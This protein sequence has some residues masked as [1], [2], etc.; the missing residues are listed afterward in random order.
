MSINLDSAARGAAQAAPTALTSG[1]VGLGQVLHAT[2]ASVWR[3]KAL[4]GAIVATTLALGTITVFA[5]PASYTSKAYISGGFVASSA[6]AQ[7]ENSGNAPFISLDLTRVI[8]T[9]RSRLQSHDLARR[10]VQQLGLEK[11][12][13]EV[14]ERHLL[15]DKFFG[16]AA[17]TQ[18]DQIDRAALRLL[19]RLSVESDLLHSYLITVSYTGTDP[20]LAVTIT[21][22]FVV[23]F[24]RSCNLQ[25]LYRQRSEAEATLSREL[26]NFGDKYPRVIQAKMRL[27]ATDNLLKEQVGVNPEILLQDAGENVTKAIRARRTPNPW[28][29]V[30]LVLLVGLVLGIAV[31]LWLERRS[32]AEAF[33]RYVRPF[34]EG[35]GSSAET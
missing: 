23:E 10:V 21:N 12:R 15:P 1:D 22:A 35:Y 25:R 26:A 14:S 19:S 13:P 4:L 3:R 33:S 5:V 9:Q 32:W 6:V 17:S 31:A 7:D 30:G 8:E 2:L 20:E 34:A 29:V 24:L 16:D 28:F 27:V 11:L 18:E